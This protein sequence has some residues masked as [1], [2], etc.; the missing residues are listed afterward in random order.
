MTEKNNDEAKG[1]SYDDFHREVGELV[2]WF[3]GS[4]NAIYALSNGLIGRNSVAKVVMKDLQLARAVDLVREL[5]RCQHVD[6]PHF[7]KFDK[8]LLLF[9]KCAEERNALLHSVALPE[10]DRKTGKEVVKFISLRSMKHLQ[11][12]RSH[13]T[14]L[15]ERLGSC[16]IEFMQAALDMGIFKPANDRRTH[17][18]V[19]HD[20]TAAG[21][22]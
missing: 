20:G 3:A 8:A 18:A 6:S 17:K 10:F 11:K 19:A 14:Q 22:S 12:E 15:R 1:H 7:R 9:K 16:T 2:F 4:E 5:A 21:A 13:I